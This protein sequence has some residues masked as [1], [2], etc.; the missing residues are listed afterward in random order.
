MHPG[1]SR[2]DSRQAFFWRMP[3]ASQGQGEKLIVF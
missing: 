3:A 1:L 2:S